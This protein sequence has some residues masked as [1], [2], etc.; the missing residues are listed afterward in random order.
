MAPLAS[1]VGWGEGVFQI[2][3]DRGDGRIFGGFEIFDL[4]IFWGMKI[5][6]SISW[7]T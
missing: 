1:E 4:G 7:V 6:A 3:S 2:S 5:L